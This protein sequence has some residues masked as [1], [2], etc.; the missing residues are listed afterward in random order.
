MWV[1][2]EVQCD[3]RETGGWRE[4]NYSVEGQADGGGHDEL[5]KIVCYRHL[6][7]Q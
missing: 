2:D 1:A 5:V 4:Y 7:L 3:I 6:L